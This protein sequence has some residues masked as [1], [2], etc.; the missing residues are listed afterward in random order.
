MKVLREK[1]FTYSPDPTVI[2]HK[3]IKILGKSK[4]IAFENYQ[5]FQSVAHRSYRSG[6]TKS[7]KKCCPLV[8]PTV[9]HVQVSE[10]RPRKYNHRLRN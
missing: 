8:S 2:Y 4:K 5:K 10:N 1:T 9:F 3:F 6:K 7:A